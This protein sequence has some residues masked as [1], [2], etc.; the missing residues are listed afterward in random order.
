MIIR[1]KTNSTVGGKLYAQDSEVE[2]TDLNVINQLKYLKSSGSID[3]EIVKPLESKTADVF[4][5]PLNYKFDDPDKRDFLLKSFVPLRTELPSKIDYTP[6]MSPVKDQGRKGCHDE[7]TEVLTKDGWK[8]F[9][10][11]TKDDLFA[12]ID[13]ET[14]EIIYQKPIHI[15]EYYYRGP[16]YISKHPSLN[17]MLTPDHR[18]YLKRWLNEIKKFEDYY[19]FKKIQTIDFIFSIPYVTNQDDLMKSN[20]K[21]LVLDP[22]K[23]LDFKNYDGMVY[24]AEIP[25]GILITRRYDKI[26]ISGNSC[27]GFAVTAVKEWQERKEY[28]REVQQGKYYRRENEQYDLSEQ[29]IY[30][31]AK[32]IDPW[33]NEE[34]TSIRYAL[35]VLQKEGIPPEEGWVYSDI[36][37]GKPTPWAKL[38]ARWNFGGKYYRITSIP[39]LEYSLY[40]KG[41]VVI[42]IICFEE[43]FYVGQNGI[44]PYPRNPWL[45]YGG[46]AV[47]LVGYDRERQLFKFKNSWGS[48]WGENGYGYLSYRYINDFMIDAWVMEDISV[49]LEWVKQGINPIVESVNVIK[50]D[51]QTTEDDSVNKNVDNDNDNI[52]QLNKSPWQK[53]KEKIWKK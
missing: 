24:C 11:T 33:P 44:V 51:N 5:K 37:L 19:V 13:R 18:M 6:E 47:C 2:I 1:F 52:N 23:D 36:E 8:Y 30:H 38:I 12:T 46:H 49:K 27:V 41:P 35:K 40:S 15:I 10:D 20:I 25:N 39:E 32:Q 48:R 53:L 42:G 29:W 16:M 3:F 31:K 50:L 45:H 34:G 22:K 7:K 17:F 4:G 9:K 28:L 14:N 21:T 26:L 43:I